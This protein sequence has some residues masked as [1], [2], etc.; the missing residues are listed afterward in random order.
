MESANPQVRRAVA[1]EMPR[2]NQ[3]ATAASD[4]AKTLTN[5]LV[6]SLTQQYSLT[7]Q[8][9]QDIQTDATPDAEPDADATAEQLPAPGYSRVSPAQ[10]TEIV[11][12]KR[13]NP[14]ITYRQIAAAIG[15]KSIATVSYWLRELDNDTVSEARKFVKTKAL[16]AA[17]KLEEQIDSSDPRVSQGAAKAITALAGVAEGNQPVQVGVQ[18]IVGTPDQP[19]GPDPFITSQVNHSSQVID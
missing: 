12:L 14:Q 1:A 5:E 9:D 3:V 17:M 8:L 15:V 13:I 7:P 4:S 2:N 16:K 10:A 19:A 11:R 6:P 18:V